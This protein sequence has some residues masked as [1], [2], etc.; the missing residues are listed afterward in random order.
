M[1]D[2]IDQ[3]KEIFG[4]VQSLMAFLDTTEQNKK[5]ENL[6]QW[7]EVLE[8][9]RNISGNP[10]P[11]LLELLKNTQWAQKQREKLQNAR[12]MRAAKKR[13]RRPVNACTC[14]WRW[15]DW[16]NCNKGV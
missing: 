8:S 1:S 5:R 2:S 6:E 10:I 14:R 15:F 3:Q 9:L 11:F 16:P 4:K 7:K 13:K 12:S